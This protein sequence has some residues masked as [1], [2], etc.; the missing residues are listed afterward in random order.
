M[1]HLN[2]LVKHKNKKKNQDSQTCLTRH[3]RKREPEAEQTD[4]I[5]IKHESV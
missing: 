5:A 2:E 1:T 4:I 3:G